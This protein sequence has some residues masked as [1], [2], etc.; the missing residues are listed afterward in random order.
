M[1]ESF[2]LKDSVHVIS[3]AVENG[4]GF[5]LFPMGVSMLP[6]IVPERDSVRLIKAQGLKKGDIILYKRACGSFVLHRIMK[7]CKDGTLILCGDN[8]RALEKNVCP[9]DVLF[10]AESY[11]KNG[12]TVK[13][14]G[15]LFW[16]HWRYARTLQLIKAAAR[17][18]FCSFCRK[19][20]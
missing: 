6:T 14:G 20:A 4:G 15:V 16:I 18:A 19:R 11:E 17:R 2:E 5:T 7:I 10:L 1:K 8:Q 9:D 13:R 3:E 12:K